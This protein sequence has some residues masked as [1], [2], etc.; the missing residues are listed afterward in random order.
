MIFTIVAPLASGFIFLQ[1]SLKKSSSD[2]KREIQNLVA[3]C[4]DWIYMK[5]SL[6][7]YKNMI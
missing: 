3:T 6:Q 1:L 7:Q 5:L 4:C 2:S